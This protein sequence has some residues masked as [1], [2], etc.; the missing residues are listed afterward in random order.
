MAD[1]ADDEAEVVGGRVA[2]MAEHARV[3]GTF[4]SS[5]VAPSAK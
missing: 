1:G 3:L 4:V 5:F 2:A